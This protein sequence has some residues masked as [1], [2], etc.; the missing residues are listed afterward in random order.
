MLTHRQG[1][2]SQAPGL[3]LVP[4]IDLRAGRVVRLVGGDFDRETV[5]GDDPVAVAVQFAEAGARWIHVVDLD[6]ARAGES[7]QGAVLGAIAS[8]VLGRARIE[9]AGGLR[10]ADEV[11]A[12]LRFAGRAVLG[13]AVLGDAGPTRE[14][15][16]AHGPERI[17]A[18]LDVR[19]GRAVGGGWAND[20]PSLPLD[21]AAGR[22]VEAGIRHVI[23]TA[24]DRDGRL[25]GPDLKLLGHVCS[26]TRLSVV[27]S[28][29]IRDVSDLRD[30]RDRGCSGAIVGRALYEGRLDLTLA[31]AQLRSES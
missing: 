5:Y 22:L 26:S 3:E 2:T 7:R 12:A 24:I 21:V 4:A 25:A 18:A 27:A 19:G 1:P 15:L 9:V 20:A 16:D 8:A 11:D 31:I 6:G 23:V 28:G 29:G 14:L 10:A 17:V 30:V 13:T